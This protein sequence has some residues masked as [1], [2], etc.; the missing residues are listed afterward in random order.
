M[1][2][3][4]KTRLLRSTNFEN[5]I[6]LSQHPDL[7]LEILKF[8]PD[9]AWCFND[10]IKHPQFTFEWVAEFPNVYWDWN[11]LSHIVTLDFLRNH[12][13]LYW[14][15]SI[16]TLKSSLKEMMNN[17]ELPWDF[18]CVSIHSAITEN[19]LPF[20]I[21]YKDRIPSWKWNHFAKH[22]TWSTLK[23]SLNLPWI[24]DISNI[25]VSMDE[26]EPTDIWLLRIYG[27]LCNWIDLTI[28]VHID[29]INE[30]DDLPWR[31]DY[32]KWN[33]STWKTSTYPIEKS[34]REWT[35]AKTIQR[36]W[37]QSICNPIYKLC[38]QRLHKEF[39]GLG[40]IYDKMASTVSFTKL[41]PDAIIPS[42]STYGSIGLDLYSV[43]PYVVLPGQRVVVS[44]GL[45]VSLP[46]GTYGRIAPRSGLAVKHGLDVGAGVIDMDYTGELRVVLFNHDQL[47]PFVIRPGYRIAQLIMEKALDDFVVVENTSPLPDT[48]RGA[49]GFG[50]SGN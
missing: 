38:K 9:Y 2:K 11:K 8:K 18:G 10:M 27:D 48:E 33:I 6:E 43:E 37:R 36:Y 14:N 21:M 7:T 22:L 42:R 12:K 24:F 50:S 39:K 4:V 5:N 16:I 49:D 45:V 32:V 28:N 19:E 29:I 13:D 23:K 41:R 26:F 3:Y 20:F 17:P 47:I 25:H 1:E 44:T 34:I 35:A 40:Q 30:H 31:K 15:W 46:E